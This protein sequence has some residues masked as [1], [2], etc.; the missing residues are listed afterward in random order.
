MA[1]KH[2]TIGSFGDRV[3]VDSA[4]AAPASA[5]AVYTP[6]IDFIPL[7]KH[8]TRFI[9]ILCLGTGTVTST[10][11]EVALYGSATP[12]GTK[13]LLADNIVTALTNSVKVQ[14]AVLD[15]NLYPAPYYYISFTS[16]GDDT[17]STALVY[18]T[19]IFIPQI[20]G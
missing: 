3:S 4:L 11:V 20:G 12:G 18:T 7:S 15:L 6:E 5:I 13:F 17:T 9:S 10:H 14:G 16:D 1:W 19:T 2:S 8:P